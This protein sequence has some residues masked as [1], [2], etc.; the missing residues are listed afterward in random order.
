MDDE[1]RI[2][3][4]LEHLLDSD[5]TPEEACER[6]PELLPEVR[7]RWRQLRGLQEHV[8]LVFPSSG[9]A[10]VKKESWPPHQQRGFPAIPGYEIESVLGRGG[11][12]VVYKA[13]HAKLNRHVALKMLLSG[14]FASDIERKRFAREAKAIAGLKHVNFVQ[15]H[16]IGEYEACPFFTMELA[17]AGT[18]AQMLGGAAQPPLMAAAMIATLATAIQVA[19]DD[20][21]IHRDL[22][23][24]NVLLA[25]DGTLKISDFGLARRLEDHDDITHTG[26]RIGTPCYMAPEQVHNRSGTVGPAADI[27]SL[28]IMLYEMLTGRPPFLSGTAA[29]AEIQ[30]ISDDPVPP[31]R[32]NRKVPR[33]LETVC[34]KCLQKDSRHRYASAAA[35]A[36]DLLRF[37]RGEPVKA[38]PLGA[39]KRSIKWMHRRP[40]HAALLISGST[41]AAVL[42]GGSFWYLSGRSLALRFVSADLAEVRRSE[43]Q[44]DWNNANVSLVRGR[45]ELGNYRSS[46]LGQQIAQASR[47]LN[48]V[49]KLDAIH[50]DSFAFAGAVVDFDRFDNIYE[51][52]FKEAGVGGY[53]CEPGL[54]ALRIIQSPIHRALVGALDGWVH[55]ALGSKQL[56]VL[57]VAEL[58]DPDP[59]NFRDRARNPKMWQSRQEL[60]KLAAMIP[61]AK[62]PV[63]FLVS[64]GEQLGARD[65]AAISFMVKVQNKN[66]DDFWINLL[67]ADA[68]NEKS[69]LPEAI[70]YYRAALAVRPHSTIVSN[71]LGDLFMNAGSYNEA[72]EQFTRE[73]EVDPTAAVAYANRAVAS[74]NMQNFSEATEDARVAVRL[75]PLD[76]WYQLLLGETLERGGYTDEAFEH[77]QTAYRLDPRREDTR[78]V[79][80]HLAMAVGR[81]DLLEHCWDIQLKSYPDSSATW[82]QYAK[83]SA[84]MRHK[85]EY[86]NARTQMLSRF[87]NTTDPQVAERIGRA[88]LLMP[89]SDEQTQRATE[90]VD[91]ALLTKVD[92]N[93]RLLLFF[94]VSHGLA[95]F[96]NRD[97]DG[98]LQT[99]HDGAPGV[100]TPLPQ[101]ISAMALAKT[102]KSDAVRAMLATAVMQYDWST[103]RMDFDGCM[104]HVLRREAEAMILP[105]LAAVREGKASSQDKTEYECLLADDECAGMRLAASRIYQKT[106][107]DDPHLLD[108]LTYGYRY[109]AAWP[110]PW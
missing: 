36:E 27:Y 83:Y 108:S 94:E 15:V 99:L 45:A 58:S 95:Q 76:G 25:T 23:P 13:Y 63:S 86:E 56:W 26:A 4:V 90:L 7:D 17:E 10:P 38:R 105:D 9:H 77:V 46:Q 1:A 35:L 19:H 72:I 82:E 101:F 109:R 107:A 20:S 30:V 100:L 60:S 24:S 103:K 22:K 66:P 8:E 34:L 87:S 53:D 65:L 6:C 5:S 93:N 39:I 84:F 54:V 37:S 92:V 89:G 106:L 49:N 104:F 79:Y 55:C 91:R 3:E 59:L 68:M 102:A 78:E 97:Y 43:E 2:V 47:D 98:A 64:L 14:A 16:D 40:T 67:L 80:R 71:H 81:F 41:L 69:R 44:G 29:A 96:R 73:I 85:A 61:V 52:A 11:I 12:G 110:P 51:A 33:D 75:Q 42:T 57:R 21:I 70:G 48:L 88:C 74:F 62:E 31:S 32:L 18:L 50:V 28:G